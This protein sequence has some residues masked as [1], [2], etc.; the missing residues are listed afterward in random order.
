MPE[1][2]REIVLGSGS[3][4]W[5]SLAAQP[6]LAGWAAAAIGHAEVNAF[7]FSA[8]DRVWIF[9]YSRREGENLALLARLQA[10]GVREL[11]YV[12]SAS[13]IVD[14]ITACY[15]YPRV[16]LAAERSTL[17]LPQG[18]VLTL[19]LVYTHPSELPAGANIATSVAALA[20]FMTARSWPASAA[21]TRQLFDVVDRPFAGALERRLFDVYGVLLTLSGRHAC[22]LR[23][24]DLVLRSL[25]MRWYGYTYLSNRL[26]ISKMS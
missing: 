25:G 21:R 7:K 19:G 23:P 15:D 1:A 20:E 8:G 3:K 2:A 5:K 26:W 22:L 10:A 18:R 12:S 16:K 9:S 4:V 14:S 11:V 13:T 6:A 17:A 24:L